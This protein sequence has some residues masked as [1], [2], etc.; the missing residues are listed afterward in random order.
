MNSSDWKELVDTFYRV[1]I[2]SGI[3]LAAVSVLTVSGN[4]LLLLAIWRDPF[5]TFRTPVTFFIIGLAAADFLTGLAV[6]PIYALH[7]IAL[8]SAMK[9]GDFA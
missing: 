7:L 8:Y 2:T 1:D 5:R 4:G 9:S 3:F 6:C